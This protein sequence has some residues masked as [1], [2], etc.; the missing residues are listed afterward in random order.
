VIVPPAFTGDVPDDHS[1]SAETCRLLGA[2]RGTEKDP[3]AMLV[4]EAI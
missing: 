1:W 2:A 3:Q 4:A